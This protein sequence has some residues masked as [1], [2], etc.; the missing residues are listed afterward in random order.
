MAF[1][2]YSTLS[3]LMVGMV[4][5]VIFIIAHLHSYRTKISKDFNLNVNATYLDGRHSW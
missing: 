2:K 4:S 3:Q 5:I 1:V